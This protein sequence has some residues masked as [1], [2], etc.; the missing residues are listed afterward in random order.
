MTPGSGPAADS[1]DNTTPSSAAEIPAVMEWK[2]QKG[3]LRR[4]APETITPQG[5][6]GQARI[7][8]GKQVRFADPTTLGVI[9]VADGYAA[10]TT[11]FK[12]SNEKGAAKLERTSKIEEAIHLNSELA[13]EELEL[14]QERAAVA[15]EMDEQDEKEEA[16]EAAR[17][18]AE[19]EELA[20]LT[21]E[22]AAGEEEAEEQDAQEE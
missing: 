3:R 21:Q 11:A 4:R 2:E 6:V 13:A 12:H 15:L 7:Y 8:R 17:K 1:R 18:A 20:Q 10:W 19:A 22:E 5:Y 14:A 16:E 9:G